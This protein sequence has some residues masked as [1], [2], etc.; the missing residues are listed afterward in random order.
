MVELKDILIE[1][2]E[3]QKNDRIE[4]ADNLNTEENLRRF[5]QVLYEK[6][7]DLETRLKILEKK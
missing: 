3:N 5:I 4:L 6:V 1:E 2:I 7:V